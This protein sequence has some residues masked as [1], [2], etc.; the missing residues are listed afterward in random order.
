MIKRSIR[1]FGLALGV[2]CAAANAPS[3][4]PHVVA[5]CDPC[6]VEFGKTAIVF[7]E[8]EDA[9]GDTLAYRWT[10]VAGVFADRHKRRTTWTA[11]D[12]D[13]SV[14]VTVAVSDGRGGSDSDTIRIRV[15][16][17]APVALPNRD[18][19]VLK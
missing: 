12:V 6:H 16:P 7:V 10:A 18:A 19:F 13:C 2:V 4:Q 9:D 3:R 14:A 5:H 11:P 1:W 8:G 15:V 17:P